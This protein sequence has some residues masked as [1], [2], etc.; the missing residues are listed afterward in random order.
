LKK[1]TAL[2]RLGHRNR[3]E[4]AADRRGGKRNGKNHGGGKASRKR[5]GSECLTNYDEKEILKAS[6]VPH[7]AMGISSKGRTKKK[8]RSLKGGQGKLISVPVAD[9]QRGKGD[10]Y[11]KID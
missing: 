8:K 4:E 2:S 6:G 11:R 1:K 3:T 10:L 9:D 5:E 7:Q